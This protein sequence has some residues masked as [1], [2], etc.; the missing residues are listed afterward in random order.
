VLKRDL[1]KSER[2][3]FTGK[4]PEDQD[5]IARWQ[6]D[7]FY[8][9][10]VDTDVA[11]PIVPGV[12]NSDETRDNTHHSFRIR[13]L[14]DRRLI[15]FAALYGI[16]WNNGTGTLSIGIGNSLD[17]GKGYG[18]EGLHLLLQYAFLELNLHRVGL[19]VISYN[20]PAIS[21][22]IR[23]GFSEEGRLREA[24]YR[25]GKRYDRLYMGLLKEEWLALEGK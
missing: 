13:L 7:S 8:L 23:A 21:S 25:E 11:F 1:F 24:I 17:R 4:Y 15:G 18:T 20:E 2:L 16:E 14:E 19:D 6:E 3:L 9:R 10:N 22:Y 5:V 12:F